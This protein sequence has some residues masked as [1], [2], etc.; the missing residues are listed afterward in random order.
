M[1]VDEPEDAFP[2]HQWNPGSTIAEG[3]HADMIFGDQEDPFQLALRISIEESAA[4]VKVAARPMFRQAGEG[5]TWSYFRPKAAAETLTQLQSQMTLLDTQME[6]ARRRLRRNKAGL[7]QATDAYNRQASALQSQIAGLQKIN[8]LCQEMHNKAQLHFRVF[9]KV[10]EDEVDLLKTAESSQP[11]Q[12][13]GESSALPDDDPNGVGAP[14]PETRDVVE[15]AE[16]KPG[17]GAQLDNA[18]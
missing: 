13:P 17:E 7:Q 9:S 14:L 6:Q 18:G 1:S 4:G 8:S 10:G 5:A 15:P 16:E 12:P 2:E 11:E 3:Q